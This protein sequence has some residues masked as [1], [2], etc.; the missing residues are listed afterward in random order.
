MAFGGVGG[1][2]ELAGLFGPTHPYTFHQRCIEV[3]DTTHSREVAMLHYLL[4]QFL[5]V[6]S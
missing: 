3:P 5:V 2:S 6:L 1:A 4:C